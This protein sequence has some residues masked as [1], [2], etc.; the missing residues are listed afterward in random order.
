M[1]EGKVWPFL[2][3]TDPKGKEQEWRVIVMPLHDGTAII[4]TI[5]GKVGGKQQKS[6]VRVREGKNLGRSNATTP[7]QQAMSEAEA[8]W[9]K[10]KDK[11]YSE[12]RGA[13]VALK[14]MLALKY[15][16]HR[17]AVTFPAYV[18]PKLDGVRALAIRNGDTISLKSRLG[19]EHVGLAHIR[20]ALLTAMFDGEIWDGELYD[21][22]MHFQTLVSLVKKNQEASS[23]VKYHVYDKISPKPFASR[24][25]EIAEAHGRRPDGL[26]LVP[27]FVVGGH[28]QVELYHQQFVEQGYEGVM[29]R[30]GNEPYKGGYRSRNLL[31]V[32]AWKDGEFKVVDVVSGK[33][34]CE[35]QGV[36]V[37]ESGGGQFGVKAK[38]SDALRREYLANKGALI[39][40]MLTVRY[41]EPTAD[42]LPRFPVGIAVRDYE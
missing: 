6:N 10:Q 23:K 17:D 41:F 18:Q 38:G 30:W 40:K 32:K 5:H 42:G 33:G 19:K 36:F 12:E 34:K 39:G 27:T 21:H 11:G 8:K 2:Y 1:N 29:L 16:D 3:K 25:L 22:G 13:G 37:C 7:L 14:P 35:D 4:E 24:N 9:L 15:E 26:I 20:T 31:K 28:A